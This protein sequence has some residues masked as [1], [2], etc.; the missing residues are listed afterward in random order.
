MEL[1]LAIRIPS[2]SGNDP[3]SSHECDFKVVDDFKVD[4]FELLQLSVLIWVGLFDNQIHSTIV[5]SSSTNIHM[6]VH[7]TLHKSMIT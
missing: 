4:I 7:F 1:K 6:L 3:I 5:E 2:L